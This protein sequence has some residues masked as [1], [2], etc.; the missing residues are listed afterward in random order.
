MTGDLDW[1]VDELL[2][3][4]EEIEIITDKHNRWL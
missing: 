3:S 1:I 4:R 2:R